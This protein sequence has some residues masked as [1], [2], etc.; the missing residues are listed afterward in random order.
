MAYERE[1]GFTNAN[2][3][4]SVEKLV[5]CANLTMRKLNLKQVDEILDM[6]KREQ[7]VYSFSMTQQE[8]ASINRDSFPESY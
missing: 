4:I 2:G 1:A 6:K 5:V 3:K 7:A 8:Q